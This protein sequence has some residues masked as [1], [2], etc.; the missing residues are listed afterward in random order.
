MSWHLTSFGDTIIDVEILWFILVL[1]HVWLHFLVL[2]RSQISVKPTGRARFFVEMLHLFYKLKV[3]F[4][5]KAIG[6]KGDLSYL[7]IFFVVKPYLTNSQRFL[8]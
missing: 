7:F 3:Y 8:N 5:R 2:G 1:S 6:S 4:Q